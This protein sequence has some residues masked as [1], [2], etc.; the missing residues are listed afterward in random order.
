M[1]E[2]LWCSGN[3]TLSEQGK[4]NYDRIF[5]NKK[6][7]KKPEREIRVCKNCGYIVGALEET[8]WKELWAERCD[9]CLDAYLKER[10]EKKNGR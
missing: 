9:L 7:E 6:P 4:E 3:Q 5:Y 10:E 1:G 2:N 8:E